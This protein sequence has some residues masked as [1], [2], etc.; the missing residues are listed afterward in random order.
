[1]GRLKQLPARLGGMPMRVGFAP[2][3]AESFYLSAPWR[4][5]VEQR[6][7]DPDYTAAKARGKPSERMILDHVVERKDGGADLDPA[8]T[9]WLTFTEHQRKTAEAKARRARGEVGQAE[10]AGRPG[11]RP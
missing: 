2:K 7:R 3:V 1:M 10:G 8:N 11:R 4:A 6:K 5:L 9:K